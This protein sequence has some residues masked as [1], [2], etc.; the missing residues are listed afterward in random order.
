MFERAPYAKAIGMLF[1]MILAT[2]IAIQEETPVP[3]HHHPVNAQLYPCGGA[4]FSP[5]QRWNIGVASN[6][7]TSIVLAAT[8]QALQLQLPVPTLAVTC[9]DGDV[10]VPCLNVVVG[11]P[12]NALDFAFVNGTIMVTGS[13]R[14]S[15]LC[16]SDSDA[17]WVT[18]VFQV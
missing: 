1:V 13:G 7:A 12:S 2:S 15:G 11:D 5:R 9:P 8:K 6:G 3:A 10:N 16:L 17:G 4:S 18:L 14:A